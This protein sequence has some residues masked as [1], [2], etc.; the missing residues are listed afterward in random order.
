MSAVELDTP[1]AVRDEIAAC[2][3]EKT[4]QTSNPRFQAFGMFVNTLSNVAAKSIE[5]SDP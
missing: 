2:Y 5:K 1:G 3:G 4:G